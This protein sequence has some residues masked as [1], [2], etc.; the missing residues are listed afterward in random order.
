MQRQL[1]M[2]LNDQRQ[3]AAGRR[4]AGITTTYKD[5]GA[6]TVSRLSSR[7]SGLNN[8][9][10]S[11]SDGGFVRGRDLETRPASKIRFVVLFYHKKWWC[12]RSMY[13]Y[14]RRCHTLL[15][16]ASLLVMAIGMIVGSVFLNSIIVTILSAVG[17]VIKGWN[18]IQR[19]PKGDREGS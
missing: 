2:L 17:T 1:Q 12:H 13:Y 16:G 10:Q 4:I 5:R 11:L 15:N 19:H 6:P 7:V 3:T 14:F 8:V 18:D 9:Y